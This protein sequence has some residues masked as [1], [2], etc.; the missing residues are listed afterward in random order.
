MNGATGIGPTANNMG[1]MMGR[2]VG[3]VG[4]QGANGLLKSLG[5]NSNS[6]SGAQPIPVMPGNSGKGGNVGGRGSFFSMMGPTDYNS[7]L[8]Q[9]NDPRFRRY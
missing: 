9:Y 4:V 1:N 8:A 7:M 5:Q 2:M 3:Q 6:M